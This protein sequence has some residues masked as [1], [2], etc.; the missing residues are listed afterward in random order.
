MLTQHVNS[1][2]ETGSIVDKQAKGRLFNKWVG[3]LD[4][5]AEK[6]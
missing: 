6:K 1:A 4:I 3:K 5:H 2:N